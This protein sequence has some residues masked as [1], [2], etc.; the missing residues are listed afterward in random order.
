MS[1]LFRG[2][3]ARANH[4]LHCE[5]VPLRPS[6]SFTRWERIW[7]PFFSFSRLQQVGFRRKGLFLFFNGRWWRT[8]LFPLLFSCWI[9]QQR[10][11]FSSWTSAGCMSPFFPAPNGILAHPPLLPTDASEAPLPPGFFVGIVSAVGLVPCRAW[12][13]YFWYLS[14]GGL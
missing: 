12:M 9:T 6:L 2:V 5:K 11:S 13:V 7:P 1:F 8:R 14:L 3:S 10:P 4:A